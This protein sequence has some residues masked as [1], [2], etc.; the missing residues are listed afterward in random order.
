MA[1]VIAIPSILVTKVEYTSTIYNAFSEEWPVIS[2]CTE[3]WRSQMDYLDVEFSICHLCSESKKNECQKRQE[4]TTNP[5]TPSKSECFLHF[6]EDYL[7]E[8]STQ[9]CKSTLK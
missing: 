4:A 9:D 2:M 8:L 5:T 3:D 6:T 1:V 7:N